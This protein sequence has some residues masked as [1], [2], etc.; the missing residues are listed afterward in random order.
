MRE[1]RVVDTVNSIEVDSEGHNEER[2]LDYP[3]LDRLVVVFPESRTSALCRGLAPLH[4]AAAMDIRSLQA[5]EALPLLLVAGARHVVSEDFVNQIV[6]QLVVSLLVQAATLSH[7]FVKMDMAFKLVVEPLS[8][9]GTSI[10]AVGSL[11]EA[12]TK[13][14]SQ[15]LSFLHLG[16]EGNEDI[17]LCLVE[18]RK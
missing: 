6:V 5:T 10:D 18:L 2:L 9:A 4:T 8:L 13:L 17:D 11:A 7:L 1:S 15:P 16:L 3:E 12:T 14:G